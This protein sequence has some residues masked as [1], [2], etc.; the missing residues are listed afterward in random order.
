MRSP[1]CPHHSQAHI[2]HLMNKSAEIHA[3][4]F[5]NPKGG[6]VFVSVSFFDPRGLPFT[7]PAAALLCGHSVFWRAK[8]SLRQSL[9]E[10]D[11][12]MFFSSKNYVKIQKNVQKMYKN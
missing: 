5:V 6:S 8:G 10:R 7:R 9:D 4:S 12:F 11:I 3:E 1:A 2:L